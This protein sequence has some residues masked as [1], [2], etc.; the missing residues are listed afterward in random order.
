MSNPEQKGLIT[1]FDA[2]VD[3]DYVSNQRHDLATDLDISAKQVESLCEYQEPITS[4]FSWDERTNLG[5]VTSF[6][7]PG[8][9]DRFI[10]RTHNL[11]RSRFDNGWIASGFYA[12]REVHL[13][14]LEMN[15]LVPSLFHSIRCWSS[16][17]T[18]L[19]G[20]SAY[21]LQNGRFKEIPIIDFAKEMYSTI[22]NGG[23]YAKQLDQETSYE[24]VMMYLK[25]LVGP[26][27]PSD[28]RCFTVDPCFSLSFFDVAWDFAYILIHTTE[29]WAALIAGTDTD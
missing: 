17:P 18:P 16:F 26:N 9:R 8:S 15:Q 14:E 11:L 2:P 12:M 24:E 5:Q 29:S 25:A 7:L 23:A 21:P 10:K 19:T 6:R 3:F 22:R 1:G 20:C 28:L 4:G 13:A 27:T